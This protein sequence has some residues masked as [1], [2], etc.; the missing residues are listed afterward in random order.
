MSLGLRFGERYRKMQCLAIMSGGMQV[1]RRALR[2]V[3]STPFVGM[4]RRVL[5]GL[6]NRSMP[7]SNGT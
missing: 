3:C 1:A 2:T 4:R 5:A 7:C 6:N